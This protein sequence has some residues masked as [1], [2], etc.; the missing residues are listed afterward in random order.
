MGTN[1]PRDV[2][3]SRRL[4]PGHVSGPSRAAVS[5]SAAV[6]FSRMHTLQSRESATIA[7]TMTRPILAAGC[8]V[9]AFA[10]GIG[11][12]RIVQSRTTSPAPPA[13]ESVWIEEL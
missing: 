2:Q 3:T 5:A 7:A 11:A 10:G 1:V 4:R 13:L 9:V 6:R 12:Q 8:L